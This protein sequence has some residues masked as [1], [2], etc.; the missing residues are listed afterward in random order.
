MGVPKT[1]YTLSPILA[2]FAGSNSALLAS[3][4][5]QE[6]SDKAWRYR[7]YPVVQIGVSYRF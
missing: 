2:Q 4:G 3:T 7:W 6:L 5:A 1:S